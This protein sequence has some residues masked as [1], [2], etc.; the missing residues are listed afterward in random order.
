MKK[1]R[2]LPNIKP[3]YI[4]EL[5]EDQMY[6]LGGWL[7]RRVLPFIGDLAVGR[8][9]SFLSNF[10][11]GDII[12][13][14]AYSSSKA[15]DF[16][17][18]LQSTVNPIKNFALDLV[19]P[20]AGS[21]ANIL[22]SNNSYG[23]GEDDEEVKQIGDT[24]MPRTVGK[25]NMTP[26][27]MHFKKGGK[28]KKVMHEFKAG[29]LHSGSKTGPLV[30]KRDQAIAIALSE[31]RRKN[32]KKETGG[33]IMEPIEYKKGGKIHIKKENKGK[34]NALKKRTG[35]TTEE[36]THSK[37]PLT[38]KRAVFAQ[39]ARKWK[40]EGGGLLNGM[41]NDEQ[42]YGKRNPLM[43]MEGAS[44]DEGG[45]NFLPDA[46]VQGGETIINNVVNSDDIT[47][48][49]ELANAYNLPKKAVGKTVA[50]YSKNIESQFEG[51]DGDPFAMNTRNRMMSVV[52]RMSA[53]LADM[54]DNED[55][56]AQY[57][58]DLN[59]DPPSWTYGVPAIRWGLKAL[60]R[61]SENVGTPIKYPF[62]NLRPT[63]I[64][65]DPNG[66]NNLVDPRTRVNQGGFNA[67][68][69]MYLP[70]NKG[71]NINI[72][73]Q[74]P[75]RTTNKITPTIPID[76]EPID[77]RTPKQAGYTE[78]TATG[79][80][81]GTNTNKF[82]TPDISSLKYIAPDDNMN[83][84]STLGSLVD[85]K[86]YDI[87]FSN[88]ADIP[89]QTLSENK[90][91]GNNVK[92][93]GINNILGAV[94]IAMSA[95]NAAKAARERP[96]KINIAPI[97]PE[98]INPKL[99]DPSYQLQNV[100][101]VFA[102]GNEAMKQVSKKD[103]LRRRIQSATEEAK[104]KSGVLGQTAATNVGIR[105]RADEINQSNAMR[106]GMFNT[107]MGLQ[108]ENINAANMGAY[109]TNRDFQRNNLA[110][111][112]GEYARDTRLEKADEKYRDRWFDAA[113]GAFG[114]NLGL[115]RD[116]SSWYIKGSPLGST[117]DASKVYPNNWN[118][119]QQDIFSPAESQYPGISPEE[120]I[121][122]R[123]NLFRPISRL[124]LSRARYSR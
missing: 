2:K 25:V 29:T 63:G 20:G 24:V 27:V 79:Y 113:Q 114:N 56:H 45:I 50:D 44:H 16:S 36:L 72:Q 13:D 40:H 61:F 123:A 10:G 69:L 58:K 43:I 6:D 115:D 30:T 118:P 21:A 7:K 92:G 104:T 35:K 93:S 4:L 42:I 68:D 48:T 98:K 116:T 67:E 9:D 111:M 46:E 106:A 51:R 52:S 59:P 33:V 84:G 81:T 65:W 18:K 94:P 23:E 28:I 32:K 17:N 95:F 108:E 62:T 105:N 39:N 120:G 124:G 97:H 88:P 122:Y 34:F 53:E 96:E 77:F 14:S 89:G 38:R 74:Q 71:N 26:N 100:G 5:D 47:I 91:I 86:K 99:I 37:N 22:Q 82:F 110:T 109:Q 107:E 80:S 15:A 11:A 57:G 49:K 8:A 101:D 55:N 117:Y 78:G 31:E 85:D 90:G 75:I 66:N 19:V 60:N 54:Y 76:N 112:L 73:E 119:T 83:I 121:N 102:T 41:D 3:K 12:K 103:Y 70:F 64:G 87:K 1:K